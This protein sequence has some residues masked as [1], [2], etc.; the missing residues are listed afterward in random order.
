M[1]A[2][3]RSPVNLTSDPANDRNA[4]WS[5]DGTQIAFASDRDGGLQLYVMRR[6]GTRVNRL[7]TDSASDTIPDWQRFSG[8]GQAPPS[9]RHP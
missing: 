8:H 9:C 1:G 7:T 6:D 2:S 5:P 4:A 3:G